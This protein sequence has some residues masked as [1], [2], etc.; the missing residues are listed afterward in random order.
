MSAERA[1]RGHS[2]DQGDLMLWIAG[3]GIAALGLAWLLLSHP[4]STSAPPDVAQPA[5]SPQAAAPAPPAGA[6]QAAGANQAAGE[7]AADS[8][9]DNPLR[10]AQLAYKAGMLDQPEQYSAWALFRQVLAKNPGDA[11][12]K[13]GLAKVAQDLLQRADVAVEQGRYDDARGTAKR[14]LDAFPD[15]SDARSLLAKIRA[16]APQA[17]TPPVVPSAP[18]PP[19]GAAAPSPDVRAAPP[20]KK[21]AAKPR[22][23]TQPKPAKQ[24]APA[25]AVASEAPQAPDLGR[26]LKAHEAFR[27]AMSGNHLLTPADTSAKHYV[28]VMTQ[29]ASDNEMTVN[30]QQTLFKEL[31]SRSRQALKALDTDAARAWIDAAADLGVDPAAVAEAR[32][33]L[34]DKVVAM[35]SQ[36]PLPASA[37]KLVSYAAPE[38]PRR[39]IEHDIEGWVDLEFTV[40]KDGTTSEIKV[41]GSKNDYYFHEAAVAAVQ[42]WRFKPR[43]LMGRTI[44]QRVFTKINFTLSDKRQ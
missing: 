44:A 26:L 29:L 5:A 27:K 8:G 41:T 24:S 17:S 36:R 43:V 40:A 7:A 19:Q 1:R 42:Q 21:A 3:A 37:L 30:A 18:T 14:V 15:D 16:A 33:A 28:A 6:D 31:L 10:M 35:E 22:K 39:A 38:Y 4:W 9:L 13:Q 2:L 20:P 23:R 34:T 32:N 11:A 12:A 25:P